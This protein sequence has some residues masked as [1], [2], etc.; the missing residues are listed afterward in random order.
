MNKGGLM[1]IKTFVVILF[2]F[3]FLNSAFAETIHLMAGN[4]PPYLSP[5]MEKNGIAGRIVTEAL[6][7]KGHKVHI[8]FAHWQEA[9]S[10]AKKGRTAKGGKVHG[11]LLWFK[12]PEREKD[13]LYSDPLIHEKHVFFHRKESPII[14]NKL[15]DLSRLKIGGVIGFHYGKEFAE[16]ERKGKIRVGRTYLSEFAF[17]FLV[18]K[19][20]DLF[21]QE[22][23]VGYH[24]L[25][26][27]FPKKLQRKITHHERKPLFEGW[28]HLILSKKHSQ[29]GKI[30]KDFNEGFKKLKDQGKIKSYLDQIK[31]PRIDLYQN[32]VR[33]LKFLK[34]WKK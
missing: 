7:M 20:I 21:P 30:F 28:S 22:M 26:E 12:T 23:L 14:F 11:T 9:F 31:D 10:W 25:K 6:A 27:Y 34:R 8:H 16:A 3:L 33:G 4:W 29:N 24:Q 13:F 5:K 19:K 2:S 18:H 32:S 15:S 17:A 1:K